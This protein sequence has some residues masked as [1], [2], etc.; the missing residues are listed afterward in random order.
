MILEDQSSRIMILGGLGPCPS[1]EFRA[2]SNG[3]SH[4]FLEPHIRIKKC[5]DLFAI[6]C[7]FFKH[8]FIHERASEKRWGAENR[9][10]CKLGVQGLF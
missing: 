8:D 9:A 3:E 6:L 4:Y 1:I 7:S 5:W 10:K 2:G